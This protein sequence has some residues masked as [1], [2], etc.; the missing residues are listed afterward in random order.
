MR[1]IIRVPVKRTGNPLHRSELRSGNSSSWS[2]KCSAIP[3][4]KVDLGGRLILN[5]IVFH[6]EYT[7]P[8]LRNLK[9]FPEWT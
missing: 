5:I 2:G 6:E 1:K 7:A 4:E 3:D 9:H 8:L